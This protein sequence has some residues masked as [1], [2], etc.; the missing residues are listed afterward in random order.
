MSSF[1]PVCSAAKCASTRVRRLT[2]LADVQQ[3][4]VRSV[5]AVHAG[6]FRQLVGE[7]FGQ[8][9]RQVAGA[10][11]GIHARGQLALRH[12]GAQLEP[13]LRQHARIAERA[14][15]ALH[16]EAVALPSRRRGCADDARGNSRRDSLT[17]HSTARAEVHV[18]AAKFGAQ[19]GIVE[20]RVVRDEYRRRRAGRR[21]QPLEHRLR[22]VR[23]ARRVRDH[24]VADSGEALD[25]RR[26]AALRD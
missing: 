10:E 25:V 12:L 6:A 2:A 5:E 17:V 9:R 4:I 3:R 8:V 11:N 24:L 19:K 26:D 15:P 1:D 14:M 22:D 16:V 7:P 23:E 18:D 21:T 20:A 13:E